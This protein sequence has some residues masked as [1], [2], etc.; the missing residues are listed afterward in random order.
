M[1]KL[2]KSMLMAAL[3]T[4]AAVCG[5]N[6]VYA[7]EVQEFSLDP[8][9]VTAERVETRDL[10][11]PALV[12]VYDEK[13]IEQSG[14]A[15]AYD[16]IQDTLGLITQS[17][18]FN[19][20]SMGSMT[21][22]VM[23]R[24]VE[25]GTLVLVNGVPINVDGKYNLE[26]IPTESIE[27]IEVVKGGGA[28]MYGS[29]ATGGVINI[30]TKKKFQNKVGVA[31]GNYGKERYKLS[32]GADKFNVVAGLENRGHASPMSVPVGEATSSTSTYNYG[33]GERKSLL[34]NY[35]IVDGLTFTHSYSKN[36]HQYHQVNWLTQAISQKNDYTDI[37]NTFLL[38]Y[39]KNGLKAT[40]SYGTQN[41]D[42]WQTKTAA[43]PF[44]YSERKGHNTNLNVQKQF[45]MGENSLL[46]GAGY[47]REDLDLF[48]SETEGTKR[49]PGTPPLFR[50]LVRDVYSVYASYNWKMNDKSNLSFN[51]RE[52]IA[53]NNH[54]TQRNLKDGKLTEVSNE[55]MSK[56]TPEVQYV[57]SV[58]E[59]A[60]LYAKAGKSFR[61]PTMTNIYGGSLINPSTN[62]KPENGTHYE[63]GYKLNEH[64]RAWRVAVFNYL[65]KDAIQ[66]DSVRD[67][68][69]QSIVDVTYYNEDIRN[70]GIELSVNI[71]HDD[72]WSSA[73]GFTLHN[74]Q[75]RNMH[76]WGDD[77]WHKQYSRYQANGMINY[78]LGKFTSNL[79]GNFVG[80]R[81]SVKS[82]STAVVRDIKPQFFTDL[83][84]SYA[85]AKNHRFYFHL[86]NIFDR[87]DITTNG[88]TNYVN[89]GRNF[90]VG[91][92]LSF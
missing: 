48:T 13:K 37:D 80:A 67:D 45:K 26:D 63:V 6:A 82:A 56:F 20:T 22:K 87:Q 88:T 32:L 72:K 31:V 89:L 62:L 40:A 50:S 70:T 75:S 38:N 81:K 2:S 77:A 29:E 12:E 33:K 49:K 10:K 14:A 39:D 74:P 61:L 83:D 55:N 46:V 17:Q 7:E 51:A 85:P 24:G 4:G 92:E 25:K 1:K 65:I 34:W 23:I 90:M 76:N 59:N 42:Y 27:K 19:G 30:I 21:S 86:N 58:N 16:V 18:G 73:W 11:T 47:Q 78:K 53:R 8:M 3:I 79:K 43:A 5:T 52:T 64:N 9:I 36:E 84:L 35:N 69:T 57:Y 28:V 44:H 68:K 41:R 71:N 60:S 15:N 91:Y 66:A 54:G